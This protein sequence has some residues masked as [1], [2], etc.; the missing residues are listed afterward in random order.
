MDRIERIKGALF[1]V[2][3]GDALGGTLEFTSKSEGIRIYGY[4]KEIIGGGVMHLK[5]GEVTDDTKMTIAVAEGIIENPEDPIK[6]IGK[7]FVDWYL[8]R[9]KDIGITCNEAISKYMQCGSWNEASLY[10]DKI[11]EGKTAGNGTLMRC[12]P[13]AL[14]YSDYKKMIS[15]T[16][17]QSQMTHYD[18]KASDACALYNTIVYKYLNGEDKEK[19]VLDTVKENKEYECI[20]HLNRSELNPSGYVVD[21]FKCA[22]WAFLNNFNAENIICEAVN[23]YGDPDTIGAIAG[24]LAGAYYGY[25]SI[26]KRWIEKIIVK[27]KL[28]LISDSINKTFI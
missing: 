13:P 25:K 6:A 23:L 21:T 18:K 12:I 15:V 27:E 26:S 3:C 10:V 4:H 17:T 8:T 20:F 24:G 19:A 22:L 7:K 11:S 5:P 9:P 16:I 14:Y 28:M 2:A 1:G